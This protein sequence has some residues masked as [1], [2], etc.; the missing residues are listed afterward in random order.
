[1]KAKVLEKF[2]DLKENTLRNPGDEFTL[3]KDR[4]EE[5]NK[6]LPGYL[7]EIKETKETKSKKGDK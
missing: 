4:F 7:K 6:K 1:M 2:K 3:T 5:I